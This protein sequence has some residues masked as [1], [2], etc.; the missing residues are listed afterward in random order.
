MKNYEEF[1]IRFLPSYKRICGTHDF[2]FK[3]TPSWTD[4]VIFDKTGIKDF[5]VLAYS[6]DDE[7][8]Y[9]DHKYFKKTCLFYF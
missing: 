3:R 8:I 9:S 5:K 6:I 4:R 7:T 1:P 2:D